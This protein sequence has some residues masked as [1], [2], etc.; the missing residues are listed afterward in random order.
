MAPESWRDT[1][2]GAIITLK[3]GYDLPKRLRRDGPFRLVSSSG[4]TGTHDIAKVDPPGVITGRTGTL[5][6]VWYVDEPFWPLNTTLYVQ[7]FKG[8]NERFVAYL[9]ETL[10]LGRFVSSSAVPG[11]NRNHLHPL[12][13]RIPDKPLQLSIAAALGVFDELI[14]NNRRRIEILEEIAR[15]FYREW[16]VHFRFPGHED[17]EFVDSDLG[18]IPEGWRS[19][20]LESCLASLV[21]GD[22]IETKDQ[23][24]DSYRLLQVS[25]IGLGRFRETGK[26]RYVTEE[27]FAL[28]KCTSII[29]GDVLVSRM[30]DPVGRAWCVDHLK[31]PSI[32]AVDVA[33]LRPEHNVD[34]PFLELYLNS[35]PTLAHAKQVSTGTT[36]KRVARS[37]L[38]QFKLAWPP[39][40]LRDGF[41]QIVSPAYELKSVLTRQ[42][43]ALAETRELLL[44][45]LV[46]GELD[47]SELDLG[48]EAVGV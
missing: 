39:H 15:L 44:P 22:W 12:P 27:T 18:P 24:G 5:G 32:T 4:V 17:V 26:F 42:N 33:I 8:N 37:V 30:P 1:T 25:N 20:T 31:K 48:L 35:G 23:G 28:L 6:E 45:R 2:L 41:Y 46:S 14:A 16:F 40:S 43:D 13:V 47:V 11:I 7:D 29:E 21:D 10:E 38:S 9:L 19:Q 36:R 3:R 34:G